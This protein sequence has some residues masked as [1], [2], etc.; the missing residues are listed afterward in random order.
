[1]PFNPF[2]RFNLSG[3]YALGYELCIE[4]TYP[5]SEFISVGVLIVASDVYGIAMVMALSE[6]SNYY[7]EIVIHIGLC[8]AL[9]IGFIITT[10]TKDEQRRENARRSTLYTTVST[11]EDLKTNSNI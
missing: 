6:L 8:L 5:L 4:Y 1:M 10:L 2:C 11:N 3:Y 7:G 9:V